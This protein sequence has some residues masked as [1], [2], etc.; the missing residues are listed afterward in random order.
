MNRLSKQLV[1]VAAL[2]LVV[3]AGVVALAQPAAAGPGRPGP[4]L[5]CGP[6]YLWNCDMP[7][8]PDYQIAAT[9]CEIRQFERAT[10]ATCVIAAG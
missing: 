9:R 5:L 10:G 6:T 1:I 3:A 2:G 4:I 8:G 7:F